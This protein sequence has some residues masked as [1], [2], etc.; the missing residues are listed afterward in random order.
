MV[1]QLFST[2]KAEFFKCIK[3]SWTVWTL[4]KIGIIKILFLIGVGVIFEKLQLKY[5]YKY[6]TKG[7]IF[8]N[9]CK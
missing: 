5:D 8:M 7:F 1:K 6:N 3:E 2:K 4:S 9:F